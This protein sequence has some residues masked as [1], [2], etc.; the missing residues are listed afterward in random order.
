MQVK[1][2]I[3]FYKDDRF[4]QDHF[5]K[6]FDQATSFGLEV[7]SSKHIPSLANV[8]K[9]EKEPDEQTILAVF[10]GDGTMLRALKRHAGMPTIGINCGSFGFLCEF[11]SKDVGDVVDFIQEG[12]W[13]VENTNVLETHYGDQRYIAINEC[14][15]SGADTGRPVDLRVRVD[16]VTMYETRGDGLIITTPTGSTA[17]NIAAGGAII[18]PGVPVLAITPIAPFL[19]LDRSAILDDQ[20]EIEILNLER[21]RRCLVFYDGVMKH[22]LN[23]GESFVIR[24]S[25]Q[26]SCFLRRPGSFSR[27]MSLKIANRYPIR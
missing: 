23:S 18:S 11:E 13:V 17:Y 1:T 27:R 16:G 10:G 4:S 6:F 12:E 2:V 25:D 8:P 21:N 5:M 19:T 9:Q 14:V 22:I 26:K 15:I 20:K 7:F 24:N 3:G